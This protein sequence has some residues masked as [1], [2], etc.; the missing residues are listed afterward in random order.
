VVK[1]DT[2]S[3][4][5]RLAEVAHTASY[6]PLLR[7][8]D[9]LVDIARNDRRIGSTSLDAEDRS[10]GTSQEPCRTTGTE[11][12]YGSQSAAPLRRQPR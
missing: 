6:G 8:M 10:R 7:L 4:S 11:D 1:N 2:H 9:V 12:K 3:T 5:K